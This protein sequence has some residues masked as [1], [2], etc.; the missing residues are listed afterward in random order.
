MVVL[1]PARD[2]LGNPG[3]LHWSRWARVASALCALSEALKLLYKKGCHSPNLT[4][5]PP[6]PHCVK[7]FVECGVYNI[8]K[9][10]ASL[11]LMRVFPFLRWKDKL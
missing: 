1:H 4:Q 2:Q 5:D 6:V 11:F 10:S 3:W 7:R 9:A 8:I